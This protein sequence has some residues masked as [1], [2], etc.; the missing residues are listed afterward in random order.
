MTFYIYITL[1]I[2]IHIIYIILYIYI[3]ILYNIIYVLYIRVINHLYL[4]G[5]HIQ[6]SLSVVKKG[7]RPAHQPIGI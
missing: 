6:V 4:T 2:Y 3:I 5:M 1:Y 7:V